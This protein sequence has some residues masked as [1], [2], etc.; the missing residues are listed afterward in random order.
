MRRL[1][2]N[3]FFHERIYCNLFLVFKVSIDVDFHPNN[4]AK[5]TYFINRVLNSMS[6]AIKAD[7]S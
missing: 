4:K 3:C 5:F 7:K 6:F 1:S 2:F